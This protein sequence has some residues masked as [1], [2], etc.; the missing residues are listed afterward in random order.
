MENLKRVQLCS[1]NNLISFMTTTKK[2]SMR[3]MLLLVPNRLVWDCDCSQHSTPDRSEF[4]KFQER[5]DL[6]LVDSFIGSVVLSEIDKIQ[7]TCRM[8]NCLQPISFHK[9]LYIPGSFAHFILQGQMWKENHLL[10]ILPYSCKNHY[11][12]RW[13]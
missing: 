1:Q 4:L 5:F 13:V 2:T 9:S 3:E 10:I 8:N 11:E 12:N 7:L 6:K